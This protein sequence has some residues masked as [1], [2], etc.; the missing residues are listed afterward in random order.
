[1]HGCLTGTV[2]EQETTACLVAERWACVKQRGGE[3]VEPLRL[4]R[5][6]R[7]A[8]SV[9]PA[10]QAEVARTAWWCRGQVAAWYR[11]QLSAR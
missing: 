2:L 4:G 6:P 1:M 10:P 11:G 5:E 9:M 8:L 7:L 3:V